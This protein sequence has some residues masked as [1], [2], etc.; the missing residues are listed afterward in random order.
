[1]MRKIPGAPVHSVEV[2]GLFIG[3]YADGQPFLLEVSGH[4]FFPLFSTPEKLREATVIG[5]AG[6]PVHVKQITDGGEFLAS[7]SGVRLMLDPWITPDGRT[8]FKELF[9]HQQGN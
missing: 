3:L 5:H 6:E 4:Q 8:R 9:P 7:V 1:M 2:T